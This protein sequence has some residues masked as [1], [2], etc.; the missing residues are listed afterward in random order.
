ML[1]FC[2]P[3]CQLC[4]LGQVPV[5]LSQVSQMEDTGDAH[6]KQAMKCLEKCLA[7]SERLMG[8][9]FYYLSGNGE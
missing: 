4:H 5:P 8:V 7:Y 3:I 6:L 9:E 1:E 2:F